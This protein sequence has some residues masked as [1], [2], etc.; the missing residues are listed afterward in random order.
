MRL[1]HGF[2]GFTAIA[3]SLAMAACGGG[4]KKPPPPPPNQAPVSNA[5]ADQSVFKAAAVTLDGAASTDADSN[6]LSYRWTQTGGTAVILSSAT[7][8]RPT[9]TAPT[10]S[11]ALTFSLVV[12]DGR[13][14]STADTVQ[15]MIAN[16]APVANAGAD[17]TVNGGSLY[18]LD[19]LG[20]ADADLD[21]MSFTWVQLAGPQVTLTTVGLGRVRF[22]API[23]NGR[24]DFAVTANDG[25]ASSAQDIVSVIVGNSLPNDAPVA[26][27]DLGYR[28]P[29]RSPVSIYGYAYDPQG[30]PLTYSWTQVTGPT[31]TLTGAATPLLSFT[32]P[33]NPTTLEFELVVSD[34][35][36]SSEPARITI[37]VE[38][39]AP[40]VM[41]VQLTP[42]APR[43][44]DDLLLNAATEDPDGDPITITYTWRRNGVVVPSVTGTTYPASLTTRDDVIV[45]TVTASDGTDSVAVDATVSI[46]DTPP[47]LS[48]TAAPTDV[49]F[50]DVVSFQIVAG[51]DPDGDPI[52][53]YIVTLG[54]ANFAVSNTGLVN[55][56]ASGPMFESTE[57]IAWGIGLS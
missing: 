2:G 22:T 54:P 24:L 20:S 34:G 8:S 14:D 48:A 49:N 53:D 38:N 42:D 5:G 17:G 43:T 4:G 16:R 6:P 23:V 45:A 9:F 51:T 7:A 29:K 3:L 46:A 36:L 27:L 28:A 55:W 35:Y 57:D 40:Q 21:A 25:E 52:G 44:L 50:G 10:L 33:A 11:G 15:V 56:Q 31:V 12:N 18:T 39:F 1:L 19:A 32:A 30:S 47:T 13:V 37:L 41:G 26:Y